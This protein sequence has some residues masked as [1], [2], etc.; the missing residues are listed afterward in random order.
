ME[1][2]TDEQIEER[3][4]LIDEQIKN[5]F[6]KYPMKANHISGYDLAKAVQRNIVDYR[7]FVDVENYK[8][9][10]IESFNDPEN[11]FKAEISIDKDGNAKGELR[12]VD[13]NDYIIVSNSSKRKIIQ[14]SMD[15]QKDAL[16]RR[17]FIHYN[18]LSDDCKSILFPENTKRHGKYKTL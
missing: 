9:S 16:L 8:D 6:S 17:I 2:L 18:D 14:E 5:L 11:I 13:K 10:V 3:A 12:F 7:V 1:K 15:V 4:T